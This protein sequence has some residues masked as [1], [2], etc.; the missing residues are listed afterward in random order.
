MKKNVGSQ[1]ISAQMTTISDGS[2]QTTGTCN[3]AVEIDGVAGTGGT[4]THIANGKWE[5]APIQADTNGDYLTFQFVITGAITATVQVYTTFPQ[6]VDH[7][8]GIADIPTV[9]EFNARSL[10]S[11]DYTIVSD[12][13]TVQT[14]DT[15][16]LANGTSGFVA[17]KAVVDTAAADVVNVDGYNLATQIGTAGAGL[18]EA[19][20][21]GD[22]FTGIAAV[23]DVTNLSNLPTIPA[24]WL[25]AAGTAADFTT[26]IQAGLATPTNI[27]AGTIT[28]VTNLTNAPT[29]GDLTAT[30]KT[31]VTTAASSSTPSV[32]VSD[33]TGFSLSTAGILAIWH[34]LTSAIV[35]AGTAG[36]LLVDNLNATVSSR[37]ATTHLDATAGK[38][39]GVAL[40]DTVTTYTGNTKQ[41][42][43]V[44][45]AINDLANATDGLGA[46]KADTAAV[47]VTTDKMTFDVTNRLDVNTRAINSAVVVGDGNATPWD[48]A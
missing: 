1:I 18:T 24:N 39:D 16:A 23:G 35:T 30:M 2:D 44:T 29:N 4:A 17:T 10:V 22:Q 15:Y 31:S 3:V 13:G 42:G 14:G 45:T 41:T 46:I 25:T 19:G 6:S 47:K 43:D 26:E 36:K 37:M 28:T 5:Y 34:Q 7:A 40:A 21:T 20:G 8:A 12:L 27:T 32:T 11:A 9:S 48:G 33:K 38:L